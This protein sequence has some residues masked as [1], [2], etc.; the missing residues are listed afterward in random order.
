MY[1][2]RKKSQ[3]LSSHHGYFQVLFSGLFRLTDKIKAGKENNN[4]KTDAWCP[5][6]KY[7]SVEL[8]QH[9]AYDETIKTF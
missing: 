4:N 8:N 7:L 2:I 9:R 5:F 1:D 3:T 6:V